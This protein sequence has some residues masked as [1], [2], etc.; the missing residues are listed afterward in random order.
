ME[1]SLTAISAFFV[2]SGVLVSAILFLDIRRNKQSMKVMNAVWVLT[3][4]WASYLALA[5]YFKF[6]REKKNGKMDMS[7]PMDGM[8]GMKM[9]MGQSH[10]RWESVALSA[11][12]C[13]AGCTLADILGEGIGYFV[14]MSIGA[15]WILDFILA[16]LIGIYFQYSAIR[17]MESISSFK[18]FVKAFKADFLSLT[19]WQIGMYGWMSVVYFILFK[20]IPL[21]KDSWIFWFMMQVAMLSGFMIAYP[22]NALLIKWGIKKGM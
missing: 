20:S 21:G 12:H 5:A 4:L 8:K 3:G 10:S 13:G 6:G 11:L 2:C 14:P 7:M 19:S 1:I 17:E 9:D 15:G 18:A 16:L 22:M